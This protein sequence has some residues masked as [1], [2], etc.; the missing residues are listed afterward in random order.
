MASRSPLVPHDDATAYIALGANVGDRIGALHH[1]VRALGEQPGL[2]VVR[3]SPVYETAA[4]TLSPEETQPP[5]L[6]AVVEVRASLAPEGVLAVCHRIEQAAGR[7]RRHERRWAPRRLDLDLLLYDA[8]TL[9]T[10]ELTL[11]HPRMGERRFVLVPLADLAPDA[12]VPAPF[13][14]TVANLL[15]RCPDPDAL[16]RTSHVLP[17][18]SEST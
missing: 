7:D 15:A 8:R 11:P 18:P 6:N 2:R 12:Y 16:R 13:D 9:Q 10:A 4:H 17:A 14:A 5:Y 1:A 3:A